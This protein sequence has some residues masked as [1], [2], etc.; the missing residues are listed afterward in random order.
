MGACSEVPKP[1]TSTGGGLPARLSLTSNDTAGH[2]KRFYGQQKQV[3]Y[4]PNIRAKS[5]PVARSPERRDRY[6]WLAIYP[7][8]QRL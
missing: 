2:N 8:A 4:Q 6:P 7:L 3:S 5:P 1:I